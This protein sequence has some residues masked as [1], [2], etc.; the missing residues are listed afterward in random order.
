MSGDWAQGNGSF[1]RPQSV[2]VAGCRTKLRRIV[3]SSYRR[4]VASHVLIS[5]GEQR[6]IV[7]FHPHA[8][9]PCPTVCCKNFLLPMNVHVTRFISNIGPPMR[10]RRGLS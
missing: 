10:Q 5:L 6:R 8:D 4:I 9:S 1:V 7:R 3:V 2:P